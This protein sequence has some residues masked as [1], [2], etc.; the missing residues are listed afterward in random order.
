[1]RPQAASPTQPE[2]DTRLEGFVV[3]QIITQVK[4]R[5]SE[6]NSWLPYQGAEL[7]MLVIRGSQ[8]MGLEIKRT[9]A[10][11]I[12]PSM[13]AALIDLDTLGVVHACPDSIA[14]SYRV[15]AIA[16]SDLVGT[17]AK[18]RRERMESR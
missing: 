5:P 9:S 8:R 6:G 12:T 18:L 11:L 14:M 4:L 15:N 17:M 7:D 16:A 1:V 2:L 3:D 13:H 10:P